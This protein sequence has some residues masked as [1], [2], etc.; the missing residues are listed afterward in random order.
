MLRPWIS[1]FATLAFSAAALGV[2]P[3]A[4]KAPRPNTPIAQANCVTAECHV[5]VK[6]SK[7]LH[8]PIVSNSCNSCHET[9]DAK[10][11]TYSIKRQKAELC[12]YCHE[13]DVSKMPVVHK[14]VAQ[15]ECLGCHDPHGGKTTAFMRED[16]TKA[17][18]ARCHEDITHNRKFVHT[19]V[20]D[21]QCDSCHAPHASKYPRLMDAVGTDL[22]LA[23]H[24]QFGEQLASAKF[25]HKALEK[26]CENCHDVHGS[27][28]PLAVVKPTTELC[29]S[30]HDKM[31]KELDQVAF[32]HTV[33][34][35]ERACMTC[36]T[37]HGGNIAKL[38]VDLPSK[39]CMNCH[40]D[41]AKGTDGHV[42]PAV[43]EI[44]DPTLYKHGPIKDG[45]CGGCHSV[46]GGDSA[47]LLAKPYSRSFY[48][49][50]TMDHYDLCFG[51]HDVRLGT[52]EKTV[53]ATGFR[54]G[55]RNL[56]FEHANKGTRGRNCRVC[57]APHAGPNERLV[58]Q[59]VSFGKWNVPINYI[60]TATGGSCEFGCHVPFAYDR[61]HP[62]G[63]TTAPS[64]RPA[65]AR[66][67][68]EP[69]RFVRFAARDDG[70][71]EISVPDAKR[72][73]VLVFVGPADVQAQ[74][75]LRTL[76]L[77]VP[78]EDPP[79]VLVVT[80]GPGAGQSAKT[81]GSFKTTD[82]PVIADAD[83]TI[84]RAAAVRGW[85]TVLIVRGDGL[86]VAR[87]AGSAE[88]LTLKMPAYIE[89]AMVRTS[90]PIDAKF[91]KPESVTDGSSIKI[92]RDIANAQV[93]LD[94][95]RGEEARQLI[96]DALAA[97][98]D[99]VPLKIAMVKAMVACGK[100]QE[101]LDLLTRLPGKSIDVSELEILR[102]K[103]FIGLGR[104]GA[105]KEQLISC[106]K[107]AQ[108]P[109]EAHLLLGRVYEHEKDW[110][111]AAKEYRMAQEKRP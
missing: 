14:P 97:K 79:A 49:K 2:I 40:K 31:K 91:L 35:S 33:V 8:S 82:W 59:S 90:A 9:V 98:A 45:Q 110:E 106:L 81:I 111:N 75:L 21:G 37:P 85:P 89:A 61:D 3:K 62:V 15:G 46:H 73:T 67:E 69:A 22:C 74:K 7:Q 6:A 100:P 105:A 4:P 11:H 44:S 78:E 66:A 93:L 55:E 101:A 77:I 96:S 41:P 10:A 109:T 71:N 53:T 51:C 36:H 70:G 29:F 50:L 16:S 48:Q 56:H 43:A 12:T 39:L 24:K 68:L 47:E 83:E 76:E 103:A 25:R 86:E 13:F 54:D 104:F 92:D 87:L 18:C 102:A 19:P 34:T 108:A 42:I 28:Q 95:G 32:K 20:K 94:A 99:S 80:M 23:C 38:A 52:A 17:L 64:T 65:I 107:R 57:H 1:I 63:P 60:K 72:P 84:A 5:N 26:G 88:A 30:C 27:D 58:R